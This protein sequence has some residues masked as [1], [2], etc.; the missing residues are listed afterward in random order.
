VVANYSWMIPT[1]GPH[2]GAYYAEAT[3]QIT[4]Y[5]NWSSPD[6]NGERIGRPAQMTKTPRPTDQS[7]PCF[8]QVAL[9]GRDGLTQRSSRTRA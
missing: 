7:A 3:Q 4:R 9:R 2:P 5:P 1:V 8:F 6:F